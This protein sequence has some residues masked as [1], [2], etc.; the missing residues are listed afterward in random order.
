MQQLRFLNLHMRRKKNSP[1]RQASLVSVQLHRR[2]QCQITGSQYLFVHAMD[3]LNP[4]FQYEQKF[5]HHMMHMPPADPVRSNRAEVGRIEADVR[6]DMRK[7]N[8]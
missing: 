5:E 6:A 1:V 4:A 3:S 8:L 7:I 2:D